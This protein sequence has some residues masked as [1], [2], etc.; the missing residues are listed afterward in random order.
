VFELD[1]RD[2]FEAEL[3]RGA[4]A[5]VAGDHGATRVDEHRVGEAE[6]LDRGGDLANL[7]LG[8]RARVVAAKRE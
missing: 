1:R 6:G 4:H 8:V 7:L 5:T 2:G 3:L